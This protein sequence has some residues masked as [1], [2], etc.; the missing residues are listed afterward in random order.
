MKCGTGPPTPISLSANTTMAQK[1]IDGGAY[2]QG[3]D[4]AIVKL[5]EGQYQLD[6]VTRELKRPKPPKAEPTPKK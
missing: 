6:P 3:A 4:G 5:E 2:Y 1:P